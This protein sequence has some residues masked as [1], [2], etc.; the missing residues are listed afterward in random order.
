MGIKASLDS[1]TRGAIEERLSALEGVL[2]AAVNSRSAEIWIARDPAYQEGPIELSVRTALASLGHDPSI[3]AVHVTLP[4][5]AGPRRRVRFVSVAREEDS[6]RVSVTVTLEWNDRL[7]EGRASG[8]KGHALELKTTAQAALEALRTLS[9]QELDLRVIGVKPIHAFD[10]DLVVA[11][12]LRTTDSAPQRLVGA[13]VAGDD[14]LAAAA[15]AVLSAVN[16]TLGNFL[17][18][19][20]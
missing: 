12:L 20:D 9:P 19:P 13:V 4:V 7:H 18:T 17:H 11:S 15:L 2:H 8:D 6:G 5:P 14:L 16:R 1:E 10:S 3:F